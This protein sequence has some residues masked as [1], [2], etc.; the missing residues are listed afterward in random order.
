[1]HVRA[2]VWDFD[3]V[4]LDSEL[5]HME[6]EFET[7]RQFGFELA[8]SVAKEY[9]GIKLKDYFTDVAGRFRLQS[10]A[11]EMIREHY[12][13]LIHYYRDVFPLVPHAREVLEGM[14]GSYAMALA[15]SRERELAQLALK[16]HELEG[17]FD[18]LIY[19]EDVTAGKPDPEPFLT[20]CE[21]LGVHP[22]EA[23]VVEDAE[24]GFVSAR[25][26]G[27]RVIARRAAHNHDLDFS[28]AHWVV[29]DLREIPPLISRLD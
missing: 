26:A 6:A 7:F 1:M 25:R 18:A 21:A 24:A 11:D 5:L 29:E 23:I 19:G 14:R 22:Q 3:G 16:R 4:L 12:K 13:T 2:V 8:E 20:A 28:A 9:F 17:Y 15:T 10:S 27:M